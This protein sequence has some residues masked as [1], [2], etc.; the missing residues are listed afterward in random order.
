MAPGPRGTDLWPTLY[1]PG[2]GQQAITGN[3]W[4]IA[5]GGWIFCILRRPAPWTALP[6]SLRARHIRPEPSVETSQP[7][8][9]QRALQVIPYAGQVPQI[10]RLAVTTIEPREDAEDLR[11]TLGGERRVDL[12]EA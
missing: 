6:A 12:D 3:V 11:G 7:R 10:L 2:T 9:H 4:L 1:L 5:I 8:M